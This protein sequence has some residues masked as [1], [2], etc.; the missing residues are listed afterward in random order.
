MV[1]VAGVVA[2]GS[3]GGVVGLL[4]LGLVLLVMAGRKRRRTYMLAVALCVVVFAT[5]ADES[6]RA[7]FQTIFTPETDYNVTDR[8]GRIQIWKR[9]VGY[10]LTHP[11]LGTGL[12]SFE[13]A[14]GMIS[15][16]RNEGYGIRYTAAHNA[17]VQIGA[18]LG[19]FG[20]IAFVVALWSAASGCLRVQRR[21][22]RDHALSSAFAEREAR[23]AA[24]AFCAL[25]GLAV[26]GFFLSIAFFPITFLA[27]ATCV[28]VHI[29]SPYG[30][31]APS[32]S[33]RAVPAFP[34]RRAPGTRHGP[35][36]ARLDTRR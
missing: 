8:E 15:G 32:T 4:V 11:V 7:R 28:G 23:L 36:V 21:A 19:V 33:S 9:G 13:T 3:R 27:L 14:E 31:F 34:L 2:T 20:L 12:N 22:N 30:R 29:G 26:T 25:C 18:E 6:Q 16:K 17:F 35:A 5:V 10:M 1:L 24:S